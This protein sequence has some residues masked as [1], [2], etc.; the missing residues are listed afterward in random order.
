MHRLKGLLQRKHKKKDHEIPTQ[1]APT[2]PPVSSSPKPLCHSTLEA[3]PFEIRNRILFAVDSLTDL[4]ALIHAS[5]TFHQQYRLDRAFWL[6]HCLYLELGQAYVD[7]Y[8]VD[9]CNMPEF[10]LRR[11]REK[12][13]LFI[14]DYK[15]RRLEVTDM[16]WKPPDEDEI[17]SMVSFHV[18]VIRPL[19]KHYVTWVRLN[20]EGLS[21][22][23][24]ISRTEE[25]RITRGLYRFQLFYNLFGPP[26]GFASYG[27]PLVQLFFDL[28]TAWEVEEILCINVFVH[29]QYL[30]VF[31]QVRWDLHPSNPSFDNVRTG[32]HTP[33]GAFDLFWKDDLPYDNQL[34]GIISRGLSVLSTALKTQDQSKL[35]ELIASEIVPM[36]EDILFESTNSYYQ[37][38]RRESHHSDRDQAQD[39]R[40]KMVFSSDSDGSPPLAWVI[41]WKETYSNLFG[42]FIPESLRQWGYVMWD[43]DRLANTD[44]VARLDQGWKDMYTEPVHY[45]APGDPRDEML[46]Y[47]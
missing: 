1:A 21:S 2:I 8:M 39:D 34:Y 45:E 16:S 43:S 46:A 36:V 22:P 25:Q 11:N 38:T 27:D 30:S 26:K 35:A 19:M 10:R 18:S 44:A 32:P 33:P 14:E 5:P 17:L 13:L 7:A 24:E 42:N 29:A 31:K 12:V 41:F 40:E 47:H 20:L 28:Y 3:L 23:N 9:Q 15:L 4:S 37:E 6:W